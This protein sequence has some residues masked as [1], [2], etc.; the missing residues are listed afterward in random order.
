MRTW[1]IWNSIR[2]KLP[3]VPWHQFVWHKLNITRY[4]HCEWLAC[5]GRLSTFH[6]LALFGIDIMPHYLL[7]AGG[8]ETLDHLLVSCLYSSFILHKLVNMV[9][10]TSTAGFPTWLGLL[11]AWGNN[12][13]AIHR[14]LLLLMAQIFCYHIWRERNARLHGKRLSRPEHFV[15]RDYH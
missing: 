10:D 6:R 13:I 1:H 8:I 12:G 3:K 7:C 4:A 9:H 5:H 14:N 15:R 2:F 11:T